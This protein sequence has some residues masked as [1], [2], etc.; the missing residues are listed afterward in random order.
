MEQEVLELVEAARQAAKQAYCPY[1]KFAVGAAVRAGNGVIYSG[2]NVE[3]ASYGL[4]ICAERNAMFQ[5]VAAGQ[6]SIQFLAVYTPT[7]LPTPPCGACRQVLNEFGPQSGVICVCDG[8]DTM[9]LPLK[10][11]LPQAF[12]PDKL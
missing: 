2:S 10:A 7:A 12:G 8:P 6:Q 11:L 3:N 1:S 5:M 9:S 4:S